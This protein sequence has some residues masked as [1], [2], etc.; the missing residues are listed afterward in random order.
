M[1][2]VLALPAA[3]SL[4]RNFLNKI[5]GQQPS[6]SLGQAAAELAGFLEN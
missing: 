1:A 3:A 4:F 5:F 2:N 6:P